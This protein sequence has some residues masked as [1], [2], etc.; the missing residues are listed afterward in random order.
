MICSG[1][2]TL[3]PQ[4]I[5]GW[6]WAGWYA[7][8]VISARRRLAAKSVSVKRESWLGRV[9]YLGLMLAGFLLIF[10]RAPRILD[11]RFLPENS[12]STVVG[13]LIEISGLGFAIW[14][15]QILGKNWSGRIVTSRTQELITS[16]GPYGI[17]RHPIYSGLLLA[18]AGT[19]VVAVEFRAIVG[20]ILILAGVLL[21]LRRE[22][23]A[24]RDH[25]G[26]SYEEYARRVPALFPYPTK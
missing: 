19:A 10:W 21:K 16:R 25:F 24:L 1:E 23:A 4:Q 15:R 20:F 3:T 26:R 7:F 6:L 18:V 22:E 9:G 12:V 14:A 5:S 13:L 2:K 11:A 8:W 17:V